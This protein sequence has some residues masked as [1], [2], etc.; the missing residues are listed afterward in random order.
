MLNIKDP[1]AHNL[2][3]QIAKETGETLT[4]AVNVALRERLHR[5]Q[6]SRR[7]K[8]KLAALLEIGRQGAKMF[9]GPHIDHAEFLYDENGLP[10]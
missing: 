9:P 8:K 6:E 1:E 7:T 5:L 10:K 2:A 4:E 3:R